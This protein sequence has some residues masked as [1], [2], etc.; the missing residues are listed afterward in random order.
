MP[1][2]M[3]RSP[4]LDIARPLLRWYDRN[5]RDLPWRRREH[6]AYAQLVAEVMLQQT[7]V[8]TVVPFYERF[9]KRFPTVSAL[10]AASMDEVL[11][12]WAGL[13]YYS[14]ARNLHAAARKIVEIHGGRVPDTVAALMRLPGVGR[15]TAGAIASIAYGVRA[16]VLDGNVGRVLMRLTAME[17]DPRSPATRAHLWRLA[18]AI[19]P[20]KRCGDFNQALMELGATVCGPQTPACL[21]C[22]LKT[23]CLAC[24]KGRAG[25][26]PPPAKRPRALPA[27][28]VVAL[29]RWGERLLFVQRPAK[30]LWAGLWELP[31]EPVETGE[32]LATARRRLRARLPVGV[33]L[34]A[35]PAGT[36]VRHLTHREITFHIYVG[37]RLRGQDHN[38][39]DP[40]SPANPSQGQPPFRWLTPDQARSL[41][42]SRACEALLR[43]QGGEGL[44]LN[45]RKPL[46]GAAVT[47]AD[48]P[49]AEMNDS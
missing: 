20:A 4:R 38:E 44:R 43:F 10:A 25:Q 2:G 8:A 34:A 29:L 41:G 35:R 27:A 13:G 21:Q 42:I 28:V 7:Q 11:P 37:T 19:L 17:A 6:D 45:R 32:P 15:Y 31:A 26:I 1:E 16:P 18:E 22:P 49:T 48:R 40:S 12:F 5:R 30:G 23:Y 3:P 46:P 24:R 33:R 47:P 14:R 9:L 36:V 39:P